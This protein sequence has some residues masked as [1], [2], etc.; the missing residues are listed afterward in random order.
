[1]KKAFT[2]I[3][4]LVVIAIIAILAAILFPVFAQAKAAAKQSVN[5]SNLKQI[6]LAGIMY[7]GDYDD[8]M[9]ANSEDKN[10]LGKKVAN[11][12]WYWLFRFSPYIKGK[13]AN[14]SGANNNI[15][16]SPLS[17]GNLAL[18]YLTE[19]S[20]DPRVTYLEAMGLDKDWGLTRTTDREG[21]PAFG[22]F[23]TYALN[24]HLCDE[25]PSMTGWQSPAES[26]MLLEATDSEIEGDELDE[27]YSRNMTCVEDDESI[28]GGNGRAPMGGNN[29]GTSITYLDGHVKWTKTSWG[30][31]DK[32][33]CAV[34][35]FTDNVGESKTLLD[36]RF[37]ASEPGGANTTVKGW[38]SVFPQQ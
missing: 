26:F 38:T 22:Y 6:G 23:A 7:A 35:T 5:V 32:N 8:N 20:K 34:A 11:G 19:K 33:Q 36:I 14:F 37:P 13:P 28:G 30:Q 21:N 29:G 17:S 16:V 2:L 9:V 27:L 25:T 18:Q 4:L 10:F 15:Y 12:S 24:E 1:M 31:G 3:E